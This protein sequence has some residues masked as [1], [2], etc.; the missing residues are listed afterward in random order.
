MLAVA[1]TAAAP[2]AVLMPP[3]IV[4]ADGNPPAW[5]IV[6]VNNDASDELAGS[7]VR[8]PGSLQCSALLNSN[9]GCDDVIASGWRPDDGS[10][11]YAFGD[12]FWNRG[13]PGSPRYVRNA[14]GNPES[15]PSTDDQ[16]A[17][18]SGNVAGWTAPQP[19]WAPQFTQWPYAPGTNP[20]RT[21]AVYSILDASN[22]DQDKNGV[23]EL[24]IDLGLL[25]G[26]NGPTTIDELLCPPT[27][28]DDAVVT[29]GSSSAVAEPATLSLLGLGMLAFAGLRRR[30]QRVSSSSTSD[31]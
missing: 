3:A 12:L 1:G 25:P 22:G 23:I 24:G 14:N 19:F 8:A 16:P 9:L 7:T 6:P 26:A 5:G 2:L 10:I 17:G 15:R 13:A 30:A 20:Q 28:N 27:C 21:A 11:D 18:W 4:A 29:N 31:S